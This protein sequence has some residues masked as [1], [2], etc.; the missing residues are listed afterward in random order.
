MTAAETT[1]GTGRDDGPVADRLAIGDL[2]DLYAHALDSRAFDLLGEVFS[3]DA[4]LDYGSAGGPHGTPTEV[5]AWI[6]RSFDGIAMTQHL[7]TNRR[8]TVDGDEA[9]AVSY[10][11]N[12]LRAHG[13]DAVLLVGGSY[14]DRLRRTDRGW[15]VTARRF[16]MLWSTR[17]PSIDLGG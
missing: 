13:D 14:H 12:P 6:E 5:V 7:I 17:A 1:T 11:L 8:I 15:R 2:L 16:E 10:L 9:T 3:P 4:D